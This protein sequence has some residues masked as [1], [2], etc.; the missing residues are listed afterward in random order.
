VFR[1]CRKVAGQNLGNFGSDH[2][3]KIWTFEI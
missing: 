1:D 2:P 3:V